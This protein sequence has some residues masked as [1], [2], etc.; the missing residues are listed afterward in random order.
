MLI[1][2]ITLTILLNIVFS[3]ITDGDKTLIL[4][5][6]VWRH[7]DRNPTD[8]YPGDAYD[9]TFWDARGGYGEL[10]TRGMAMHVKLGAKIKKRYNQHLPQY[11]NA[12]EIYV[13]STDVNRTIISAMSNMIGMYA[14]GDSDRVNRDYPDFTGTPY[15]WPSN[16]VPIAV[17]TVDDNTDHL[18]NANAYCPRQ[19]ALWKYCYQNCPEVKKIIDDPATQNLIAYINQSI[20]ITYRVD[21]LW[22][23]HDVT[24]IE[25]DNNL[26]MPTWWSQSFQDNLTDINDRVEDLQDGLNLQA[27]NGINF[28]VELPKLRAGALTNDMRMHM[29][30]KLS[31]A[32]KTTRNCSWINGLKYYAYSAHDETIA[33]FLATLGAKDDVVPHGYPLYSSAA[34]V[35]LW[36]DKQ[37]KAYFKVFYHQGDGDLYDFDEITKYVTGCDR[38]MN[39]QYCSL[40]VFEKRADLYNPGDAAKL[41][42]DL[43]ILDFLSSSANPTNPSTTPKV[44]RGYFDLFSITFTLLMALIR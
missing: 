19:D 15:K 42:Q 30:I 40:D 23:L 6:S 8:P 4:V 1:R 10:T 27:L 36:Q 24:F 28:A 34:V 35:E 21:E 25:N 33:S 37:G 29:D 17:H 14:Q 44:S 43:S 32:G 3:Q 2:I 12:A 41:C 7:G 39:S 16:F 9:K 38:S 26:K 5:Q 18:G 31:C 22:K 13:R 20:G 11:Y